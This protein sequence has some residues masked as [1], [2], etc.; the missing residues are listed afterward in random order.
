MLFERKFKTIIVGGGPA[1]LAIL[2]SA[3]RCGRLKQMLEDGLLIL[4]QDTTL[5]RGSI[6]NYI[7]DSD[8]TGDTFLDPLRKGDEKLLHAILETPVARRIAEAGSRAIPLSDA[9]ELL[10]RIGCAMQAIVARY[11]RSSVQTSCAAEKAQR[12]FDG[13][14]R[15][16]TRGP[17]GH[18]RIYRADHLVLATGATQP[19]RRLQQ[20][21]V[22]GVPV[23]NRWGDRLMQSNEVIGKG[24]LLRVSKLVAGVQFPR[25]AILGGST[26]AMAVCHSLL[27]R[28]PGVTFGEGGITLFHRRPLR[29]YYTSPEEALAEGYTEFGPQDLCPLT[30]RVYRLAGLRLS[31]RELL[32]QVRGIGGRRLEPRMRMHLLTGDDP[33]AI[34]WIDSAH[35]VI[36]A[37]GYR[38]RGLRMVDSDGQEIRT[39]AETSPSAP[40]VDG[41]CR[42]MNEH[43]EPIGGVYGIGLA[44]GFVPH[45]ELGGEP[46]FVG[47][48][49]G[50]WLW[51]TDVGALIVEAVTANV[52]VVL[53]RQVKIRPQLH[54]TTDAQSMAVVPEAV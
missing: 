9:G 5:G 3:H 25:I 10:E 38:P 46:S 40:M 2:L 32:M 39:F 47:Q 53:P 49:N 7:I 23:V 42:V 24:G 48:A 44:A 35:V 43:G 18:Q 14:W 28:T 1:G 6:G 30:N 41:R 29:V 33:E 27:H 15:I 52:P 4:E 50:L 31:S 16:T 12:G 26:S 19:W 34:Q 37:F 20:E 51:Q 36:V 21:S 45:G 11:P 54:H 22:S 13:K 8:S 17:D